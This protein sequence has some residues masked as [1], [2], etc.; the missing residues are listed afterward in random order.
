MLLSAIFLT[1][2]V[3]F[4]AAMTLQTLSHSQNA[5]A[6]LRL[7]AINL[8]NEQ[9]AMI[10]SLAAQNKLNSSSYDFLG[11]EDDLKSYG[12]F[13]E[14][15]NQTPI[16]FEVKAT[17]SNVSDEENLRRVEVVVTWKNFEIDFEK[18]VRIGDGEE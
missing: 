6:A 18:I 15:D 11:N 7:H 5:D 1:V 10:E 3:S 2:I 4:V 13:K 17:V 16:E 9:F 12:L 14:S 8:A